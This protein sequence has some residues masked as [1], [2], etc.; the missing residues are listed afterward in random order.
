M[1]VLN[2]ASEMH[3]SAQKAAESIIAQ[4][5]YDTLYAKAYSAAGKDAAAKNICNAIACYERT[6]I[7]LNSRFDK[8]VRGELSFNRNEID[9]FNLFMG[10]AKCGTC[11][12]MPLFSGAKPPRY[13][14]AETEVIGVP[15]ANTSTKSKL[16]KDEGR[17]MV[18]GLPIHKYAFKTSSLRNIALTAPYMHNGVFKTLEQVLDFYNN[19]GGKGLKIAPG[20]QT[21]PFEKLQLSATEKKSIIAFLKTL[22]D[23]LQIDE[24]HIHRNL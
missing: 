7:A 6:L 1:E 18:T 21:L 11:H 19:G 24:T 9:G 15:A 22:T 3:G 2:N 4:K 20:N 14:Y 10:K 23:T 12:F 17:F 13:Y 5:G 16:D 8:Q